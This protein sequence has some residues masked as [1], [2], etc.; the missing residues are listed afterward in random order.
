MVWIWWLCGCRRRKGP[1]GKP[2]DYYTTTTSNRRKQPRLFLRHPLIVFC[3]SFAALASLRFRVRTKQAKVAAQDW[4]HRQRQR[5]HSKRDSTTGLQRSVDASTTTTMTTNSPS[6]TIAYELIQ[7]ERPNGSR[8]IGRPPLSVL[9]FRAV[10][11]PTSEGRT[12]SSHD[13][14]SPQESASVSTNDQTREEQDL[15]ST[16]VTVQEW[17]WAMLKDRD[18]PLSQTT[19]LDQFIQ[20]LQSGNSF[21]AYYWETKGVTANTVRSKPFEFVLVDAPELQHFVLAQQ[22][23]QQQGS[24]VP[25]TFVEPLQHCRE[26]STEQP[27]LFLPGTCV[28]SNLGRDAVLIVPQPSSSSLP[29]SSSTTTPSWTFYGHLATFVRQAPY[30][31]VQS[32]WTQVLQTYAQHLHV[33]LPPSPHE[34]S[35]SLTH[36]SAT[37]RG[38][39][40]A[41]STS[42]LT[43][44]PSN[45]KDDYGD[46]W[47]W[48]RVVS[49]WIRGHDPTPPH[50]Q[51][52]Q[53]R[54]KVP[55]P[56]PSQSSSSSSLSSIVP[57]SHDPDR[58][59]W[60]STCGTG[61]AWVHMRLDQRPKY[62]TYTPFARET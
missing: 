20:I 58:P 25:S 3:L 52:Q 55:S 43:N 23:E 50:A 56:W 46:T 32:F 59:M 11:V 24:G 1:R 41:S 57:I 27:E 9:R 16:P 10:W 4:I 39:T 48:S 17:I 8:S 7:E 37:L 61:V 31:Q 44:N 22:Q 28:F 15:V 29:S 12:S 33:S 45:H 54:R 6:R 30:R 14:V 60:L 5:R 26:E 53:E 62:Y 35:S 2:V 36:S 42:V 49:R 34:L 47:W 38:R 51:Q 18:S 21:Q 19:L 40:G 13:R